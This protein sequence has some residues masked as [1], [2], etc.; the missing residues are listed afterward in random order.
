MVPHLATRVSLPTPTD[1]RRTLRS[2]HQGAGDP[3]LVER[4][5]VWW[6]GATTDDGPVELSFTPDGDGVIV[7]AAGPGLGAAMA[8][9]EALLGVRDA[10]DALV[11]RDPVVAELAR[12]GRGIRFG[13]TFRVLDALVPVILGQVVTGADAIRGWKGIVRRYGSP[14]PFGR[15]WVPPDADRLRQLDYADL[16]PL[17]VEKRRADVILTVARV[18]G[19]LEEAVALGGEALSRRLL[20][21]PGV[22]P[23]TSAHVLAIALG[24]PDAVPVGDY[25]L[26]DTVAWN[27]AGEPRAD[28]VRMLELLA[29]YAGQ[30]G[31]LVRWIEAFGQGAPRF[32]PRTDNRDFRRD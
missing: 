21:I 31:R 2:L 20:A 14:G 16:H 12:H 22:G 18:A 5:G 23:W 28:D 3:T 7:R 17:G 10:P 32:G 30:R 6:R 9:V 11:P 8:G 24:D 26:P 1:V 19:R 27:L 25:H 29:P 4:D 13:A 15:A